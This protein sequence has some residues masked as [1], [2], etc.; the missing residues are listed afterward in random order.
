VTIIDA[1]GARD[2]RCD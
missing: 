2:E 1:A